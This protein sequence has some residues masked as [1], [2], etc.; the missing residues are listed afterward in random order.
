MA[1]ERINIGMLFH[2]RERAITEAGLRFPHFQIA[3]ILWSQT[4]SRCSSTN[5]ACF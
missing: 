3:L 2:Q 5:I 4:C 1:V